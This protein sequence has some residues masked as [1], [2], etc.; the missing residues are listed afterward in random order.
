MTTEQVLNLLL[1]K[2]R[3]SSTDLTSWEVLTKLQIKLTRSLLLL[4]CWRWRITRT[5]LCCIWCMSL[6]VSHSFFMALYLEYFSFNLFWTFF[7]VFGFCRK[8]STKGRWVPSGDTCALRSMWE[9]LQN[10]HHGGRPGG[11]S[12]LWCGSSSHT[13]AVSV[14]S[15]LFMINF[16]L[17]L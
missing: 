15:I 5:S 16:I 1:H 17:F 8:N 6:E 13:A 4:L 14:L 2:F 12:Y 9:D 3:V 7:L 10:L 11:G